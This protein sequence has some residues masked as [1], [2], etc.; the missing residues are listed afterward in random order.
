M[1]TPAIS[2]IKNKTAPVAYKLMTISLPPWPVT[3]SSRVL[4]P[5]RSLGIPRRCMISLAALFTLTPSLNSTSRVTFFSSPAMVSAA[6]AD[7]RTPGEPEA[8]RLL[9]SR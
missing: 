8:L 3:A 2:T 4:N 9:R 5:T 6:A 1:T 7:N